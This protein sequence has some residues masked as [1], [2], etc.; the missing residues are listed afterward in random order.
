MVAIPP[1][2]DALPY[3]LLRFWPPKLV[4][5]FCWYFTRSSSN[6]WWPFFDVAGL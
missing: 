6:T 1:E 3:L 5:G 2:N 4:Y